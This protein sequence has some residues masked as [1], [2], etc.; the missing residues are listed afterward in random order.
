MQA[1]LG[2]SRSISGPPLKILR[3]ASDMYPDVV[4]GLGIHAHELSQ[5]QAER[6]HDVTVLTSDHGGS[7]V[8]RE[9]RRYGYHIVRH[10]ELFRPLDNSVIPGIVGSLHRMS[11]D[12]DVIHAHS[13]LFLST[14][15]T[16]VY[17]RLSG[18]P[19][20]VTNH[21][22]MSQTAPIWAQRVFLPTVGRFTL[23]S[24]NRVL[25][26][27]EADSRRLDEHG[28]DADV[29]VVHNGVDCDRFRPRGCHRSGLQVMFAGRLKPGKGVLDLVDAFAEVVEAL[30]KATLKIVGDGP[31]RDELLTRA[32]DREIQDNVHLVGTVP[33]DR[34]PTLYAE[35]D[36]FVLP[37]LYE[38]LPRTVLEAMASEVPVVVS[39]LEQLVPLVED[40]GEVVPPGAPQELA[41]VLVNLLTADRR[42]DELGA[43]GRK[44]VQSKYSWA[45]TVRETTAVCR[46]LAGG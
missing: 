31:L 35:C 12:Y 16:A 34:M 19:L 22:L 30:P 17:S 33:Y 4:G 8:P 14:N 1:V 10:R 28:I 24:A 41:S 5:S 2:E 18:V 45:E 36:V 43:A 39:E 37:S 7:G 15:L 23:E 3:V 44:R 21:G 38:G 25:C 6:G 20:V 40:A 32:I 27:T 42:R 13:H 11:G 29:R 9:E 26:Y 46:E